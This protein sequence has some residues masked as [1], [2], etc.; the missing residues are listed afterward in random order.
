MKLA[1]PLLIVAVAA[2]VLAPISA[3][4]GG[5]GG[6]VV[7][8]PRS[9]VVIASPSAVVVRPAPKVFVATTPSVFTAVVSPHHF[10]PRFGTTVIVA[11][12]FFPIVVSA[13]PAI[14]S[15]PPIV[16]AQPPPVVSVAPSPLPTPTVIEY[17]TGWYQLCGD[18]VTTPYVWVWIPKPPPPP[19]PAAPPAVP[20]APPSTAPVEPPTG[21]ADPPTAPLVQLRLAA[22]AGELYRWTDEHGGPHWTDRLDNIPERYRSQ[23]QR[24]S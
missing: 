10:F 1:R 18:G 23:A 7:V 3:S 4:A 20:P 19:P 22:P 24:L 5:R 21:P 17:P 15:S 6:V 14:V 12:P 13:A 11:R 2:L 9:S 16:Y 8:A